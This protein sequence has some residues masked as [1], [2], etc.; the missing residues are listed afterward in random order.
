M[1]DD[2]APLLGANAL[3]RRGGG[4][5]ASGANGGESSSR[6]EAPGERAAVAVARPP[7]RCVRCGNAARKPFEARCGHPGCYSCWLELL[8]EAKRAGAGGEGAAC[9][10]CHQPV[11]KRQLT[12][13]FFT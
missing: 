1:R 11:L 4:F 3:S 13:V 10:S 12:K 8:G 6:G 9:P 2:G 5:S 7:P